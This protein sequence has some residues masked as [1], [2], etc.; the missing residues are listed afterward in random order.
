MAAAAA[1]AARI[2]VSDVVSSRLD[3]A[4]RLGATDMVDATEGTAVEQIRELTGG[5]G[6]DFSVESTGIPE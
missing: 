5:Q 3:L 2:I 4:A 1:G 6:V